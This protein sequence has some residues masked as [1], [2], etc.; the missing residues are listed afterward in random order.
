LLIDETFDAAAPFTGSLEVRKLFLSVLL[1]EPGE[2]YWADVRS[3]CPR[4]PARELW[5]RPLDRL[6]P[7]RVLPNRL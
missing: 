3:Q 4:R 5:D 2:R 1:A 6:L 7:G